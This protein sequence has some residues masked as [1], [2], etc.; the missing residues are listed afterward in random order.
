MTGRLADH[1]R[2]VAPGRAAP[3]QMG[4]L[5]LRAVHELLEV[6]EPT[7]PLRSKSSILVWKMWELVM[8]LIMWEALKCPKS[9]LS[10]CLVV[11]RFLKA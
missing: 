11:V 6:L 5:G 10:R 4:E 2:V 7:V 1:R 9:R 8:L 3:P